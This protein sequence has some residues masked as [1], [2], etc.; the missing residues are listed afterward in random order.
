MMNIAHNPLTD[1]LKIAKDLAQEFAQTAAE[2][3]KQG[4]NPKHERDLIRASGLL[5]L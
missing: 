3:D 5:T 2:R 4:G 1:P